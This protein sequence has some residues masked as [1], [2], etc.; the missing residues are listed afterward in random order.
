MLL[1]KVVKIGELFE[2]KLEEGST[3]TKLLEVLDDGEFLVFQPT[4]KGMLVWSDFDQVLSF[5]FYRSEGVFTF[6]AQMKE[7]FVKDDL[8][9]CRFKQVTPVTKHQRRHAYRLPIVLKTLIECVDEEQEEENCKVYKGK[10]I[11]I[12]EKSV[13]LTCFEPLEEDT[14]VSATIYYNEWSSIMLRSKVFR[15]SKAEEPNSPYEIVL[16]F[17]DCSERDI[18]N[19]RRYILKQQINAKVKRRK[20]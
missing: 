8:R 2:I 1:E 17:I 9:V 7:T 5:A 11:N 19:L 15:C 10:T 4:L 16:L 3:R 13:Q 14:L 18:M 20:K 6:D 12:S